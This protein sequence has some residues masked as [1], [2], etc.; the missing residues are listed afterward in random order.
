V[1]IVSFALLVFAYDETAFIVFS[2]LNLLFLLL[3]GRVLVPFDFAFSSMFVALFHLPD[4]TYN[5]K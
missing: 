2:T 3:R 4:L 1:P 5:Y